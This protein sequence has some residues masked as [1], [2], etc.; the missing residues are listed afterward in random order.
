MNLEPEILNCSNLFLF[1]EYADNR[2]IL[3]VNF[4]EKAF[5]N[6][7]EVWKLGRLIVEFY[8]CFVV[9]QSWLRRELIQRKKERGF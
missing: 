9:L 3:R 5:S 7:R 2:K 4:V 8:I 1:V 6:I